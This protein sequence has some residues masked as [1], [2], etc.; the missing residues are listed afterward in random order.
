MPLLYPNPLQHKLQNSV[1]KLHFNPLQS[2]GGSLCIVT[3]PALTVITE[4]VK[5]KK[6]YINKHI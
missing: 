4:S 1:P 2:D 5:K 6:T 3:D